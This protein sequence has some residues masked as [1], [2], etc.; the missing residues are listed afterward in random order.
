MTDGQETINVVV[1]MDYSDALIE[2]IRAISPRLRVERHFPNV[3]DRVWADTEV[4]YTLRTF[5]EPAEVPR[6]RWIQM[7]TAGIDTIENEPIYRAQDVEIT[8]ASGVHTVHLSEFC[9]GMM[10]NFNY[11]FYQ[12]Q[13]DQQATLWRED[14]YKVYAPR[15]LRGQ[16]VGIVGY[17]SVGRELAR[18]CDALGMRVLAIKRD[19]MHPADRDGFREPGTG[20]PEGEIPA[21]IYPPEAI[22]SMA[23]ECDFLVLIAPLTKSTRHMVNENVFRAMKRTAVLINVARGPV[24]DE[25]DLITALSSGRIAGAA[26]DVFEEEP[27]PT[28]SPLWGMENVLISPHVAGFNQRYN[29]KTAAVFMENLERYLENRPLI[30]RVQREFGY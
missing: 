8:T 13:R 30:N 1:A 26:L 4:L 14:R 22:A 10:L 21:R 2:Q 29:E 15:E 7:H 5:P 19:V 18:Q 17:G 12:L 24:V 27:L 11:K 6:L 23:S 3:P 25:A 28:T 9:L 16:T 20:D